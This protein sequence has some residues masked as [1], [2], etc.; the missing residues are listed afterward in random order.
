MAK[1]ALLVILSTLWLYGQPSGAK[2]RVLF[3][4]GKQKVTSREFEY[5]FVKNHSNKPGEFTREGVNA[6]LDLFVRFKLKVA[7]AAR[8]G[9][10]TTKAFRTEF[11]GYRKEIKKSFEPPA[12]NP[13]QLLNLTYERL[14]TEVRAAHILIQADPDLSD[15]LS[16]YNKAM[17][18][19]NRAQAGEDFA[20]LARRYSDDPSAKSNGGD[21]GYFTALE[22]VY[23]FE[24]TAYS[25][26]PGQIS[27]PVRTRFGYHIVK[28]IDHRPSPPET[29]VS[30]ILVRQGEQAHTEDEARNLIFSISDRLQAGAKWE[31][32]CREYSEDPSTRDQGGKLPPFRRGTFATIAPGFEEAAMGLRNPGDISDPVQSSFGWHI[33]RLEGKVPMA[34]L[35]NMKMVLQQRVSRDERSRYSGVKRMERLKVELGLK[36]D[37]QVFRAVLD[38]ADSALN[39]GNWNFTGTR[40]LAASRLMELDGKSYRV[41]DFTG[42]LTRQQT[43]QGGS[44][45]SPEQIMRRYYGNWIQ[46]LVEK[47]SDAR[48]ERDNESYRLLLQEYREGMMLFAIMEKEVWNKASADTAGQRRYFNGYQARYQAGNRIRARIYGSGDAAYMEAL[49]QK[50][51]RGD[52]VTKEEARKLR[53][54]SPF[55]LY[56]KGDSKITDRIPWTIGVHATE[57]DKIR[58]VV[59]V[60]ALVPPGQKTFEEA[61]P[62]VISDYQ[63][64][65]EETWI[66]QLR[67]KFPVRNVPA[68][69]EEVTQR[70]IASKQKE[71]NP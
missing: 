59:Q 35:Q 32:I 7:E 1:T 6:Y 49:Q 25:T 58:Y 44:S 50:L 54:A 4:M 69:L 12:A 31:D 16:A 21:L 10:D 34:S 5:L 43:A 51:Q 71:A 24:N 30:H 2:D 64:A 11:E 65:L 45:V 39:T 40:K 62:L 29:E 56:E 19:R 8:R 36:E 28:V 26:P 23:P 22:M 70:I 14:K 48:M 67:E 37:P 66:G 17:E 33:I 38:L 41:K 27:L 13:E 57:A 20:D 9:M 68:V 52:S 47:T 53:T 15:T 55:R 3:T 61:R 46:Q 60:T 18:L 42:W 63:D